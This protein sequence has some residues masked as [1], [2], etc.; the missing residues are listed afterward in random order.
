[1]DGSSLSVLKHDTNMLKLSYSHHSI[2]P[3]LSQIIIIWSPKL[4]ILG[5]TYYFLVTANNLVQDLGLDSCID[6]KKAHQLTLEKRRTSVKLPYHSMC[7]RGIDW[8]TCTDIPSQTACVYNQW[9]PRHADDLRRENELYRH[10]APHGCHSRIFQLLV[11]RLHFANH[12][13]ETPAISRTQYTSYF[14]IGKFV[15][16]FYTRTLCN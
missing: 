2:Q 11:W 13:Y 9:Q 3:H 6:L 8:H 7:A 10:F 5:I 16:I 12:L 4:Y 14:S 1:M 15:I